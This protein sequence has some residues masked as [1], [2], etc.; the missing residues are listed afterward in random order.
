VQTETGQQIEVIE[1]H[2]DDDDD[3]D[4]DDDIRNQSARVMMHETSRLKPACLTC[5]S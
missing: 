2:E 4:D 3:D 5:A 1:K